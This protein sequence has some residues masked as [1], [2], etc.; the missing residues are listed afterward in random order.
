MTGYRI[1]AEKGIS[2]PVNRGVV[3][4]PYFIGDFQHISMI[5]DGFW[6]EI[7]FQFFAYFTKCDIDGVV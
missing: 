4:R 3:L 5:V 6:D 2:F 1:S 7:P